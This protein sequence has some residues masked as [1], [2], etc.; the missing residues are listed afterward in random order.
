M[1]LWTSLKAQPPSAHPLQDP[2]QIKRKYLHW[3]IRMLSGLFLGYAVFYFVRVNLSVA[4]P[5]M[6]EELGIS[7]T[8]LG[9][10]FSALSMTYGL[11]KFL[12][13]IMADRSNI[14]YF[15]AIGLFFSAICNIFF[16]LSSSF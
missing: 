5:K 10:I 1:D 15:M 8:D 6:I 13:G 11:S 9:W 2:A 14:R 12:S 16:G 7:K 3:R 4:S